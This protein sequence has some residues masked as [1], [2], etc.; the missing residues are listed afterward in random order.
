MNDAD[1]L[2]QQARAAREHAYAPYSHFQVGAAVRSRDGRMFSGCNV[3]NAAYGLCAC[4]ERNALSTAVAA[5]CG[6][7]EF[8]HLAVIGD[9]EGPISPCG[10]CRQMIF[11]LGGSALPVT[12]ANLRGETRETTAGALLPDAFEL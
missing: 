7:G 9:T 2:L 10:A 4:A 5:G 1:K 12:L 3:E 11:E 6:R 8:T